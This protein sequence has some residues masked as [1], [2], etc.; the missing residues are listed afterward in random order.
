MKV[1]L[2]LKYHTH[3]KGRSFIASSKVYDFIISWIIKPKVTSV[4]GHHVAQLCYYVCYFLGRNTTWFCSCNR[5]SLFNNR[6]LQFLFQKVSGPIFSLVEVSLVKKISRTKF[7]SNFT[8]S[9]KHGLV[10]RRFSTI[11]AIFPLPKI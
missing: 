2:N 5:S 9:I 7:K 8:Y 3:I 4:L 11:W 1:L 6:S 10:G